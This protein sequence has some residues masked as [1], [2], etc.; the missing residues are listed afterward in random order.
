MMISGAEK[1]LWPVFLLGVLAIFLS[2]PTVAGA[3]YQR[4]AASAATL[5][6]KTNSDS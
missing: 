4:S 6:S 3:G 2:V 5:E 1:N